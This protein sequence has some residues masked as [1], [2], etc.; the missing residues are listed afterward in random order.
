M[1]ATTVLVRGPNRR[2]R[3][4]QTLLA[5]AVCLVLTLA[6]AVGVLGYQLF[7]R[8]HQDPLR[9][10][11]AIVVLGGEHDGREDYGLELAADGYA[12][13]VLISDPYRPYKRSEQDLMNRVCDAGTDSIEVICFEPHPS[14]TRG[15]AM[16]VQHM[17][18]ARGWRSVIVVSWRY[19]LVRARY[20][21]GQCSDREV[22]MR[23]VPRSYAQSWRDWAYTYAYQYGGLM[24]AT[25]LGC[26]T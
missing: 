11:D 23:S 12:D 8:D 15:E 5:A 10:A 6:L 20:I 7:T 22:V 17:A 18:T 24:K 16:F 14:T 2:R 9:P 26:D 19:H 1:R 3:R 25:A 4:R 21:F 13:T